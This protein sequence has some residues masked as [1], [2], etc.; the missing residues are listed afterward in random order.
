MTH[1]ETDMTP[2]LQQ[3]AR[4]YYRTGE[5]WDSCF[6]FPNRRSLAF[7]RKYLS[8]EMAADASSGAHFAPAMFTIND[9]FY[10]AGRFAETDKVTLLLELYEV[11]KDLSPLKEPLDEFIFWGD[12]LLAD[13]DDVDKYLVD[14]DALFTNVADFKGIQDEFSYLTPTQEE[15]IRRF[16]DHFRDRVRPE[17]GKKDIKGRFLQ[18]W[19]L[20]GPLYHRF[21]ERLRAGGMAYEGM[22]YRD[23]AEKIGA[24]SV[25]DILKEAFPDA[26]RFIFVGLNALNECEKKVLAK[27]QDA[28]LAGFCWDY[29]SDMI[30]DPLNKSSFFMKDFTVRFPQAFA[31]DPEGLPD[32]EIEVISVPSGVGQAKLLPELLGKG[33]GDWLRTAVVLPDEALLTPVLG[34][35]PPEVEDVNV[36]MG[37]PMRGSAIFSLIGQIASMQV[38]LRH[39]EDGWYFYHRQVRALFSG[40]LF[41]SALNDEE[42]GVADRVTGEAKYYIPEADLARGGLLSVVFRPVIQAP[43][44]PDAVQVA[45]LNAYLIEVV[46]TLAARLAG[47][48][49]NLLELDFAK[50][51]YTALRQLSRR[52]LEVLPA[53]WIRILD[54]MLSTLTVPF[55]GEPLKGLQVMGP[56]ETRALDFDKVIIL[57]ANEGIFP[58]RS[59]SSSFIPPELRKGFG[60]PT[61]EFQDAVWAYYFYRLIQ[62][63]SKVYLVY[64]SRTEGLKSGEESRYIKQL[65]YHFPVRAVHRAAIAPVRPSSADPDI[66][67]TE[68]DIEIIRGKAL[69]ASSLQGYLACQAKF[70]YHVVKGLRET[71]DVSENLD[72]GTVGNVFHKVMQQLYDRPSGTVTREDLVSMKGDKASLRALIDEIIREEL[73]TIE[74]AGRDLVTA[75]VILQY[76]RKTLDR[77][78]EYLDAHGAGHF[79]I[80]GLEQAVDASVDGFRFYG[81]VDRL[82]R[83]P[84]GRVRIVDYKTGKVTDKDVD[85]TDA[86]AEAVLE[87]LFGEKNRNRPKIALQIYLYDLMVERKFG[88][89]N[90][91]NSIYSTSRLMSQPVKDVETSAVFTEKAGERLGT[92]LAEIADQ[93]KPFHRKFD[94][95]TC[96]FCE[97]KTLC[98]V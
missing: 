8:G 59:V 39:R 62:R 23:L 94:P 65:D 80:L 53:T 61:Y 74:V 55:S 46:R 51:C 49:G 5:V 3:V 4:H 11:Y 72:A 41:R 76:V 79:E 37:Y 36:T 26:Q 98:A 60:L 21:R 58:R 7:F 85:I 32:P 52:P 88:Y 56:L 22:V 78:I 86:N 90:K 97:F 50:R 73:K 30:R 12:V 45:A 34:S 38:H 91:V 67:K 27:M 68:E 25:A 18:I 47:R 13:F 81:I 20:L 63:A 57:S 40:S 14:A 9:F 35:I 1:R 19:N 17:D 77:D 95:D 43:D 31:T 66:P 89:R 29:R 64:D 33:D 54:Q 71:E 15:A 87:A 16:V 70:Y 75:E 93:G 28:G 42:A 44:R 6:V 10:R 83:L 24:E 2:F 84:G 48:G 96:K 92:L 82:D 69:S